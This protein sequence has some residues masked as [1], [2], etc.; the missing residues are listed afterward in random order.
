[1]AD[2]GQIVEASG[3]CLCGEVRNEVRGPLRTPIR[4]VSWGAIGS[5]ERTAKNFTFINH[6][7]KEM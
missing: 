6:L 4:K 3:G 5:I 2:K 7:S 1:M